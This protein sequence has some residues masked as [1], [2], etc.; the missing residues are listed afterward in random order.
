MMSGDPD[1]DVAITDTLESI[2]AAIDVKVDG[3]IKVDRCL[4]ADEDALTAEITR[5]TAR[6]KSVANNRKSLRQAL[7]TMM[8]QTN[9]KRIKTPLA[10]VSL[11]AG[12]ESLQLKPDF[13]INKL[14]DKYVNHPDPTPNKRE[15]LQAVQ[16]GEKFEGVEAVRTP[17]LSIR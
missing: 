7:L 10:T 16:N 13:N 12:R 11:T 4:K 5:L 9:K 17:G 8:T 6:K 15:L 2:D 3:Y 14:P 1:E